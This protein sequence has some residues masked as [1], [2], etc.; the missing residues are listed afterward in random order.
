MAVD[1]KGILSI[2]KK[3]FVYLINFSLNTAIKHFLICFVI[4]V[5]T[6][7]IKVFILAEI[8]LRLNSESKSLTTEICEESVLILCG[9]VL[10]QQVYF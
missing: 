10:L 8:F 7:A 3:D 2:S 9:V 6:I 1:Q 4:E 5:N